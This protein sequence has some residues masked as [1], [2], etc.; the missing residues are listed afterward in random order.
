MKLS[1]STLNIEGLNNLCHQKVIIS[2]LGLIQ[3]IFFFIGCFL[4]NCWKNNSAP[5]RTQK[6]S[7]KIVCWS[8]ALLESSSC[9]TVDVD[10]GFWTLHFEKPKTTMSCHVHRYFTKLLTFS[11]N[12]LSP[13]K[14]SNICSFPL[15]WDHRLHNNSVSH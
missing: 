1:L 15:F 4:K 14:E 6:K 13:S 11:G 8:I 12:F 7:Y 5:Y 2:Q 3:D 10:F 9:W